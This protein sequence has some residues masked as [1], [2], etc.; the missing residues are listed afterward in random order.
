[1]FCIKC[2]NHFQRGVGSRAKLCKRCWL[3]AKK[4][5]VRTAWKRRKKREEKEREKNGIRR[6][7]HF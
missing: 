7:Y 1:M 2:D 3:K 6:M 4:Q 5:A